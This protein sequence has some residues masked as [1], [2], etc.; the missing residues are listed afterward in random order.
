[1]KLL[2][3]C[4][5]GSQLYGT[6]HPDSDMDIRGVCLPPVETILGSQGF[7]QWMPNKKQ[8]VEWSNK[9]FGVESDD[10]TIYGLE[11]FLKLCV[12]ANPNI[13]EL[14]FAT[15]LL[16]VSPIWR[17]I[18][19][20][21]MWFLSQKIIYTFSG[22]AYSQFKRIKTHKKWIDKGWIDNPPRQP[23]PFDYGMFYTDKGGQKWENDEAKSEY[24]R[25]KAEIDRFYEWYKNRNPKRF[26]LEKQ[27]GYDVKHAMHLYRLIIECQYLLKNGWLEFPLPEKDVTFLKEILKGSLTYEE[28]VSFGEESKDRLLNIETSLPHKPNRKKVEEFLIETHYNYVVENYES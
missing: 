9:T 12:D 13:I 1:M 28:I 14:L 24:K 10:I 6:N 2:F 4:I 22:Y 7:E 8:A 18:Q 15:S 27:F 21:Y 3:A 19:A 25:I 5:A 17:K 20:N 23:D 16:D 11:K 26:E